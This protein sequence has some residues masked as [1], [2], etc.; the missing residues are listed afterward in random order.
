MSI[1]YYK[2]T[3]TL[4]EIIITTAISAIITL[5][6]YNLYFQGWR[7]EEATSLKSELETAG[8]IALDIMSKELK[9]ATRTS[10]Q[11]PSPNISIT[12]GPNQKQITFY[13]PQ[14]DSQKR[15]VTDSNG[16]IVWDKNNPI[17]YQYIPGQKELRRLEKGEQK[18]LC[19]NVSDVKFSDIDR[20]NSLYINELKIE[21]TLS[22]RMSN[23]REISVSLTSLIKLRN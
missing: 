13:L 1:N 18:I 8:R 16:D 4:S 9:K 11:N 5:I 17:H 6:L 19:R 14:I 21:L 2:K 20:D 22:K 12:S 3:F 23:Q 7:L 10:S 15:V